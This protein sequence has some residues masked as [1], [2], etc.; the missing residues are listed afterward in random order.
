M[1]KKDSSNLQERF[2]ELT[3]ELS[4]LYQYQSFL[5]EY[6]LSLELKL[7]ELSKMIDFMEDLRKT[8]L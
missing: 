5:D 4:Y 2:Y 1:N 8:N 6:I 3:E 7:Q